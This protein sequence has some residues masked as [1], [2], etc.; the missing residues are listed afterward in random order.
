V[1]SKHSKD[2]VPSVDAIC[3]RAIYLGLSGVAVTDHVDVDRGETELEILRKLEDDVSEAR[4]KYSGKLE[5]SMGVELGEGNHDLPLAEKI[6]SRDSLDFVIGSMHRQR[7]RADYYYL[8]YERENLD[9]IM[10]GYY[11]ELRE[12]CA[13]DASTS[14][15]T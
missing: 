13:A 15:G 3:E 1:H 10:R 14:W 5:I 2:G 11:G 8:D 7:E 6:V 12:L 4:G 9:D